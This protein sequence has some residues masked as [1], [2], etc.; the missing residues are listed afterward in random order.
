MVKEDLILASSV[1][2]RLA[3]DES[4][5]SADR[6]VEIESAGGVVTI[7]GQVD[8]LRDAEKIAKVVRTTPGVKGAILGVDFFR[9]KNKS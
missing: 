9:S 8:S 6:G 1:R 3:T 4:V 2:A 7:G 5:G